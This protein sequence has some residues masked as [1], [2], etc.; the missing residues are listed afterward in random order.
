VEDSFFDD[1]TD[2]QA[3][4]DV[5]IGGRGARARIVYAKRRRGLRIDL[6]RERMGPEGDRV[7]GV[8]S[9]IGGAGDD[10]LIGTG[11]FNALGGGPGDDRLEGRGS[12]DALS[13]GG[14]DDLAFGGDGPD[15]F[16]EAMYPSSS[17]G[18]SDRLFGG[19][20]SD[21]FA[22]IES[23]AQPDAIH[24]DAADQPVETQRLDRLNGR[25]E[26]LRG[27]DAGLVAGLDMR[28][29]PR[30][31]ADSVVYKLS[32]GPTESVEEVENGVVTGYSSRCRGRL[33]LR[34]AD[35]QAGGSREFEAEVAVGSR[36]PWM[37]V[38]VPLT[39]EA[40]RAIQQGTVLE[41]LVE[42]LSSSGFEIPAAGY[43]ALL[44]G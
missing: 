39:P 43:R 15:R 14:G 44:R 2:A 23:P 33:S 38:Q 31:T 42:P 12:A 37:D 1:E 13:G 28:V 3:S 21:H 9:V 36:T 22:T 32:C 10:V 29:A 17:G 20:G 27:W 30:L 26:L 5:V 19:P 24:C 4:R 8:K 18:G 6:H 25:C 41:V 35:G 40:R 11:G 34:T 7:S 16:T